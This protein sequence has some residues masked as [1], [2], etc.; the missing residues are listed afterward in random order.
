MN[1]SADDRCGRMLVL[2]LFAFGLSMSLVPAASAQTGSR[3]SAVMTFDERRPGVPTGLELRI[4]YV[5]PAD[6]SAKPPAVRTVIEEVAE[7]AR[8]D[9]SVPER[10]RASDPEL[11]LMGAAVCPVG[12]RVG[13]GTITIDTGFPEPGRFV[14]ADVVFLNNT[15]ELI[16]VSTVRGTGARVISRSAI[17]GRRIINS[18]PPL[19]GTPPDG[20]AIDVAHARLEAISRNVGGVLRGYVTTPQLCPSGGSWTNAFSF[21]YA[22]G[23]TQTAQNPSPCVRAEGPKRSCRGRPATIA[24]TGG[25]DRIQGT[26]GDDVIAALGGGDTVHAG[27]GRDLICGG[28]GRDRLRGGHGKDFL[29]GGRGRDDLRGGRA[30]DFLNGNKGRD[31]LRGGKGRDEIRGGRGR[32][33]CQGDRQGCS[34]IG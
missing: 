20:G 27:G 21:T 22:D 6:P 34:R 30:G 4:D 10:C 8:I 1:R 9:T 14:D 25:R 28:E 19:P 24:G 2:L 32:D 17:E 33:S 11:I 5:N 18:A 31:V 29:S 3:Q 23:I 26:P 7:G 16:F 15:G 13:T 12:S